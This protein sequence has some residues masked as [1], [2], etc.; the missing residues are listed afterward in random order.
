MIFV[1]IL[2]GITLGALLACEGTL[3]PLRGQLEVGRDAYA[4]FVAGKGI[5]GGDL[6]AVRTE[7]GSAIPLT[8]T[9]VGEMRP[10]LSPDGG[11]VAFVRGQSLRDSTPGTVW[12]MNLLTGADRELALPKGAGLPTRVGWSHDGRSIVVA[13][14]AGLYRFDAPPAAPDPRLIPPAERAAAESSLAVLLGEPVFTRVVPCQEPGAL[15]VAGDT[16]APG[17]LARGARDATRWGPDSVAFVT[18]GEIEIRPLGPGR[19]RRLQVS[20]APGPLRQITA[21]TGR[22]A[23]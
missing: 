12:V 22:P 14:A 3:P 11:A 16:G 4:V 19:A 20:G 21:F 8:F 1:R 6:Y 18:G 23:P 7:G 15:C 10:A 17:L 5:A 2:S 13:A 9:T